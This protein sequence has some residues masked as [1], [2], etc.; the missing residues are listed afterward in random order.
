MDTTAQ[1]DKNPLQI[2]LDNTTASVYVCDVDN[3]EIIFANKVLKSRYTYELEG[4]KCWEVLSNFGSPC[5]YCKMKEVLK[6]PLG[7][8]YVWE[9]MNPDIWEHNDPDLNPW[10]HISQSVLNWTDGRKVHLVTFTDISDIKNNEIKLNEYKGRLEK[11]LHEKT[12]SERRL[13]TINDNIEK[14]SIFRIHVNKSGEILFDYVSNNITQLSGGITARELQQ[15]SYLLLDNIY[16]DD[17]AEILSQLKA[18][19]P[20]LPQ[21]ISPVFR[22]LRNGKVC[23]YKMQSRRNIQGDTIVHDGILMDITE[24]KK[25]EED[26]VYAKVRAEESD[27]L[28]STF[29][30]NMSHEIRTPMN[31]ILGFLELIF[32]EDAGVSAESKR[33]FIRIVTDNAHQ[34][35]KL[36]NDLLD[37]SR[38]EAGKVKI[39]PRKNN[40]NV[41]MQDILASFVT[42]GE[43]TPEK[44]IKMIVD[45]SRQDAAGEFMI[46]FFRLRQILNNIIG[47]AIKF[48][49]KGYVKFGYRLE[50]Q[51]LHFYV[52]DTGIGISEE[53]IKDIYRPFHQVYDESKSAQYGGTGMG[54]AICKYLVEL[55]G[56]VLFVGS[57]LGKGRKF[58]FIIPYE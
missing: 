53:K 43:I 24:Q 5:P 42:S 49:D 26:L 25:L 14:T 50:G 35:M 29:M 47:N 56:G 15:D 58:G 36:I 11:L 19:L 12:E 37:I 2:V 3:Y 34:L 10:F 41:L 13:Q 38:L 28:K 20:E 51:R 22:F 44:D 57:T 4:K 17:K 40:L 31:A 9:N 6:L 30:A 21:S 48:T 27:K 52:E 16:P 46:D 18:C 32:A 54:L 7:Q 55:M 45:T 1:T 23:W 8:S 39:V 33:E